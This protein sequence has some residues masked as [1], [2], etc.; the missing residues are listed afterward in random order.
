M[1]YL[2]VGSTFGA[3]TEI[4]FFAALRLYGGFTID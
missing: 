1:M 2:Q 3:Q 4:H